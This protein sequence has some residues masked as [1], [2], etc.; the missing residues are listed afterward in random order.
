MEEQLTNILKT[1]L[2]ELSI[3]PQDEIVAKLTKYIQELELFNAAYDLVGADSTKDIIIRHILDSLS[4]YTEIQTLIEEQ[5]SLQ[6]TQNITIGDIGTGGG[7]PG[8]P[9]AICFPEINFILVERMSKRCAFLENCGAILNLQNLTVINI[10]A[11]RCT[12]SLVDI[13]VFRAF[14][15]LDK[16]MIQTLLKIIKPQGRLA[17]YKAKSDKIQEEMQGIHTFVEGWYQKKLK[18]PFLDN[19]ERNL[20]IIPKN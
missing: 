15:P 3:S 18:V 19:T 8:I 17:A 9:L 13:A 4:A 14:R 1:G 16:K 6:G 2:T 5:K 10:E 20:V 7:L 12:P 11:E